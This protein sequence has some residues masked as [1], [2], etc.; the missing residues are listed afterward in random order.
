[1][2]EQDQNPKKK[3]RKLDKLKDWGEQLLPSVKEIENWLHGKDKEM[4]LKE[5]GAKKPGGDRPCL[6]D[7]ASMKKRKLRRDDEDPVKLPKRQT[8]KQKTG[9]SCQIMPENNR[10]V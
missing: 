7:S 2:V 5:I 6:G 3:R 10:N 8:K 4:T 1:M 9:R